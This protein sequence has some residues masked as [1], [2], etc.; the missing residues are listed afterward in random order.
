MQSLLQGADQAIDRTLWAAIRLFEQR[1]HISRML[2]QQ[3]RTSGR[4]RRAELY[5]AR[6]RESREHAR[7]LR[8]LHGVRRTF[9]D[10]VD[11]V[12]N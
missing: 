10:A 9:A 3:E 2:G 12:S 6:A 5:E 7:K 11:D 4:A 1:A 8:E